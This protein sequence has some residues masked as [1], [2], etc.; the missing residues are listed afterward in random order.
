MMTMI[1]L[2]QMLES[3]P[4][5]PSH[6]GVYARAIAAAM[7]CASA[8]SLCADACLSSAGRDLLHC[9]RLN[10]DCADI[11]SATVRVLSRAGKEGAQPIQA[12]LA[13]CGAACRA[14]TAE[15]RMHEHLS[16][17][18]ICAEAC[19]TCEGECEDLLKDISQGGA[20]HRAAVEEPP[21]WARGTL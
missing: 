11:C 12:L 13:A 4:E 8:S 20:S 14:A 16:H 3:H 5:G 2:R 1:P 15:C 7:E 21:T 9:I 19:E 6:V 17:C 18:R 10:L